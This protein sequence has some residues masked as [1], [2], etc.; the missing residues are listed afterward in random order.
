MDADGL[1][2]I[3]DRDHRRAQVC[4]PTGEPLARLGDLCVAEV[5]YAE[6]GLL[7]QPPVELR[8]R[9]ELVRQG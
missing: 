2:C 9:H 1:T 6:F 5:S 3:G 4:S 7:C 8:S